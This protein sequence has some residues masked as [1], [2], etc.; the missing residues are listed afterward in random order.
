MMY[1][2]IY[3]DFIKQ[4]S[5]IV[6]IQKPTFLYTKSLNFWLKLA[7]LRVVE[8]PFSKNQDQ[9][10][11]YWNYNRKTILVDENPDASDFLIY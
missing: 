9:N 1:F 5:N 11:A 3:S 2:T 4:K 6:K 8:Q 7:M 10:K